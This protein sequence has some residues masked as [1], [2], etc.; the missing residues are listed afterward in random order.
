MRF[1]VPIQIN[2]EKHQS[3]DLTLDLAAR[4]NPRMSPLQDYQRAPLAILAIK[5][6]TLQSVVNPPASQ[7]VANFILRALPPRMI[8]ELS[9]HLNRVDLPRGQ[10]IGRPD[11][12]MER[13][14][15]VNRGLISLTR[16][17]RDG[18]I[19]EIGAIGIEGLA[20]LSAIFGFERADV[21][22][23]VQIPGEA[24]CIRRA[25]LREAMNR[26]EPLR[27]VL[28]NYRRWVISQIA[29][30]AACNCLHSLKERYCRWLLIA[31]DSARSDT[32][33]LTHELSASMLGAQRP[34]VSV[35]TAGLRKAGV[36]DYH[37]G[38]VTIIDRSG[39][40]RMSCECYEAVHAHLADCSF[41]Q[42]R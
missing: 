31:H 33:T 3:H 6:R 14:Y 23:I 42:S 19:A 4:R 22:M 29:Q 36:I 15:F 8:D 28:Q 13:V 27:K 20:D 10:V 1:C 41:Q 24:F 18:R 34:S 17:M 26:S 39:L 40:K 21:E 37:C 35:I 38:H 5:E 16:T 25:V 11:R 32:F 9:V 2:E 7:A 12:P 30:T